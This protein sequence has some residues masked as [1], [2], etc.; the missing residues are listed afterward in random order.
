MVPEARTREADEPQPKTGPEATRIA[1]V[2]SGV[3]RVVVVSSKRQYRIAEG[4][5]RNHHRRL[6]GRKVL[7]KV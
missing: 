6:G 4:V 3:R 2:T 7:A 1:I 5:N